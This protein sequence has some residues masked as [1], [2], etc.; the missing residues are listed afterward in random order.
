MYQ[1]APF[2]GFPKTLNGMAVINEVLAER[3]IDLPLP[4]QATVAEGERFERGRAIQHPLY[5]DEIRDS[6]VGQSEDLRGVVPRLPSG[7]D[8][9]TT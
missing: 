1:C 9:T 2:L 5:G 7:R 6:L 3:G 8:R 4:D